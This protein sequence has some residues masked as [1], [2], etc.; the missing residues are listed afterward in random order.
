MIRLENTTVKTEP[1]LLTKSSKG[2]D[3]LLQRKDIGFFNMPGRNEYWVESAVKG[4]DLRSRYT[5]LC[6]LGM[7]GS[8]LGT[9]AIYD[10]LHD[11]SDGRK[12]M[13]FDNIDAVYFWQQ[14][15][16]LPDLEKVH[17][18]IVTKSGSTLETLAMANFVNQSLNE[19]GLQLARHCTVISETKSSPV[20]EWAREHDVS[21][22]EIP[23][24]V[25]G[26]FSVLT[27][28]GLLPAR[29]MGI[30][31]GELRTGA[32][33]ALEQKSLVS[34]LSA[35]SLQSFER[36][37]WITL[38]WSYSNQLQAFGFWWQQLWAESLAKKVGESENPVPRVSSPFSCLG[39]RDQHS[40]LQQV[41]EGFGDKFIWF[42]RVEEAEKYGP[43][44][45][46]SQ[47]SGQ[48][49]TLNRGLG[50][51][52]AAQLK[53]TRQSLAEVGVQSLTLEVSKV[54]P[55]TLGALFML[56]ELVVG[57]LGQCLG[58]NAYDQPGVEVGKRLAKQF[59]Q[60]GH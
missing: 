46:Q 43:Q 57:T 11:P 26:R 34:E 20:V 50:E 49:Y 16:Q 53:A 4:D 13:F 56:N 51:I 41:F 31:I 23:E 37:E 22:L 58:I 8:S 27:P 36:D 1:Q 40:I 45:R 18:L 30:D 38:Q 32:Q 29:F 55:Q 15:A 17:W 2:F 7:G 48:D 14:M 39:P 52:M 12:L 3:Q 47:F 25:G 59:M 9:R 33:W 42:M 10:A 60:M 19:K 24:D 44:L 35:Q 5:T 54:D 28:V 6:V 21:V